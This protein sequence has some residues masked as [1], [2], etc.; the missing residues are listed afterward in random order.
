MSLTQ[1]LQVIVLFAQYRV[2]KTHEGLGW[3]VLG[4]AAFASA[5][6]FYYLR[7]NPAY[8]HVTII[9]NFSLFI[10]AS[11]ALYV[12]VRRFLGQHARP[13]RII[14]F[15]SIFGL[16]GFYFAFIDNNLAVRQANISAALALCA[17]SI[18]RTLYVHKTSSIK[19]SA[20]FLC[21]VFFTCGVLLS[22]RAFAFLVIAPGSILSPNPA[23]TATLL[24][25]LIAGTLW[26]FGFIFLVNQQLSAENREAK[27]HFE[28][29]FNTSPDAAF[30]IRM[31]DGAIVDANKGLVAVYGF[32]RNELIGK[33]IADFDVWE[34]QANRNR[35]I[36]ELQKK[37]T[38]ENFECTFKRRDG[39]KLIA[40]ISAKSI[41]LHGENHILSV[42]RDITERKHS[43]E[44]QRELELRLQ[45]AE[46]MEALGT[47]AGGVAHDLNNVLG[48]IVGYSE[49]LFHALEKPGPT[50][51]QAMQIMKGGQRAA[52]IVHD[53]LTLA[54][55]GVPNRKVL[56][57]NNIVKDFQELSEF[58]TLCSSHAEVRVEA[59]LEADLLNISASPVH[60][61]KSLM[62]LVLNAFEAMPNGGNLTIRTANLYPDKPIYGYDEVQE[63]DYVVLSVSDTG[64]GI[65]EPD[66]KH[67]FEPFYTRKAMGRS[68]TGLGLAVVWGTVK[69]HQG[70]INVESEKG[71]GTTFK[72]YF[73]VTRERMTQ[74][75]TAVPVFE[76]MGSGQSILVVDDVEEQ[77]E[78]A[79]TMLT[80]LNYSVN[81]VSSGAEA[82]KYLG[83]TPTDLV[84]LDMI[85]DPGMDG[86]DT[87]SKILEFRPN[88]KAIIVS[89]YSE[90]ERVV[91][92]Q[93]I[94]AGSYVRKPYIMEKLGLAV[95]KELG[96]GNTGL[97][98]KQE[99]RGKEHRK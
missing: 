30:I 41:R 13:G 9:L 49:M 75:Q 66:L 15:W 92:A 1:V 44:D 46:K 19:A 10:F 21:A 58:T 39:S 97:T 25:T 98:D 8:A 78:L 83:H 77:R 5:Y 94:G 82:L 69:D 90:T 51:T 99:I 60:I 64:E 24:L 12:G 56:N 29:I 76:Y 88:Q 26:T 38:C 61:V 20:S 18:A 28:L 47:M 68:G 42:I 93:Q 6:V 65:S 89:G 74:E 48:V 50:R 32:S 70:Y 81:S 73:P 63:G 53:L 84:I 35:F 86:L 37:G 23:Q 27:E 3:W 52:S 7:D 17:F 79:T 11:I 31:K 55:R 96:P 45:R 34:N 54:R 91:K 57:L 62:N 72:L 85:M 59:C 43:E 95:R 22:A 14:A 33:P 36:D 87:Y 71:K 2:S 16:I 4:N 67:I 80:R 40:M